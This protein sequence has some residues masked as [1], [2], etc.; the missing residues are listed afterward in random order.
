MPFKLIT[1]PAA[2]PVSLEQAKNHCRVDDITADDG[3]ITE[4]IKTARDYVESHIQRPLIT[5]EWML[6]IDSFQCLVR[7]KANLQSVSQVRYINSAGAWAVIDPAD[8]EIDSVDEVGAIYPTYNKTWPATRNTRN[9][10]EIKF[11]AGY[12]DADS[13]PPSIVEAMLLLIGHLYQNRE[14]VTI[15]VSVAE[16]PQGID[17]LLMQHRV[18]FD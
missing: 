10:I 4:L 9:A 14:S 6:Y 3:L 16:T 15:G 12:G 5:Q 13:V 1:P 7:L 11:I 18:M 2:E 17:F 8:Y